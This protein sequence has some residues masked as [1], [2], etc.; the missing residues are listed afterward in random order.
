MSKY[1]T[2]EY[3]ML[4]AES[5]ISLLNPVPGKGKTRDGLF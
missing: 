5:G 4:S 1:G 3:F 2:V